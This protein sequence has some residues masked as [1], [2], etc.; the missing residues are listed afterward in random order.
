MTL[1]EYLAV[2]DE[3]ARIAREQQAYYETR[4]ALKAGRTSVPA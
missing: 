1:A 2:C 4:A 3:Q